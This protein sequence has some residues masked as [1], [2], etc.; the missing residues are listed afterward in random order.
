MARAVAEA[1]HRA[2]EG[3][4]AVAPYRHG[5]R[6]VDVGGKTRRR[7]HR[8][9]HARDRGH[10]LRDVLQV[11]HVADREEVGV[12]GRLHR[13]RH[14]LILLVAGLEAVGRRARPEHVGLLEHG[15]VLR[16]LAAR[17]VARHA[18]HRGE[19]P[20]VGLL[21]RHLE[22]LPAVAA[23]GEHLR[24][25]VEANG[26]VVAGVEVGSAAGLTGKTEVQRAA[27][28]VGE[29]HQLHDRGLR[30]GHLAPVEAHVEGRLQEVGPSDQVLLAGGRH[31]QQGRGGG[32][33][34]RLAGEA[35]QRRHRLPPFL[36]LPAYLRLGSSR[37]QTR[38]TSAFV[39]PM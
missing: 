27:P 16:A 28:V 11:S 4:H 30:V 20:Q 25:A 15:L 1:A 12:D 19:Q 14:R 35:G 38:V 2:G 34:H 17:H 18:E 10:H 29:H 32:C 36:M 13:Q 9:G 33:C 24:V 7:V 8:G 31:Y 39:G 3:R 21:A 37:C 22:G 5:D 26:M 6:A 23:R